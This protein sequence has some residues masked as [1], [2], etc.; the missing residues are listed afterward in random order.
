MIPRR[1]GPWSNPPLR[2][3]SSSPF[4]PSLMATAESGRLLIA[5]L[6]HHDGV[7]RQPLLYLSLYFKQN[8]AEYYRL[9]NSAR[10]NR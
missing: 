8:R 7:L 6:L 4:T 9:L 2:M 5:L 1:R 10:D 3:F